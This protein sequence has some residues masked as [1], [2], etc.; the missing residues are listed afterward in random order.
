MPFPIA[1]TYRFPLESS[2]IPCGKH[3]VMP[4]E[5][6]P[7]KV[8]MIPVVVSTLRIALL[9]VSEIQRVCDEVLTASPFGLLM[10]AS[11]AAPPSP[12]Y[13]RVPFPATVVMIPVTR[14]TILMRLLYVSA[15]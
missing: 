6:L 10:D 1:E 15:M 12:L 8:V 9:E 5:P 3:S 7:K 4:Q 11:M 14:L 2:A 13:P